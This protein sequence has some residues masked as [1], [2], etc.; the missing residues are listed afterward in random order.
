[1]NTE[2]LVGITILSDISNKRGRVRKFS[3]VEDEKSQAI[4]TLLGL[5]DQGAEISLRDNR[6]NR[7]GL[8]RIKLENG[9][10]LKCGGGHGFSID[11]EGFSEKDIVWLIKVTAPYNYG[12]GDY[13][14]GEI[15][16]YR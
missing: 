8:I 14:C 1:M 10:Y 2:D 9:Q 15:C 13:F 11:W 7:D 3:I 4:E 6:D 5:V 16:N 12:N